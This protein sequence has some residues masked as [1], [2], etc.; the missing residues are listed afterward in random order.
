[1][2]V[3]GKTVKALGLCSGGLDSILSA[4]VLKS[5]GID[6]AWVSFET[7]FFS[8]TKARR[9]SDNTGIPLE[10]RKITDIYL[11][12]LKDPRSGYGKNMNPCKDCHTLMFRLAGEMMK[13]RGFHFLF[14]GEVLEQR[15]LSQTRTSLRY[16]EKHSGMTDYILRPLSAKKLPET[17]P[18]KNG[19]VDRNR[20]L[21]IAG[22][23]RKRQI[24]LARQFGIED[25]PA[26]AGGC[27]LT[28]KNYCRRLKDLFDHG[29]ATREKDLMLLKYGRHFRLGPRLKIIV[30]RTEA[31]NRQI[32][33]FFEPSSDV[34][35]HVRDYPS[36]VVLVTGQW[37]DQGLQLAG[38]ICVGYSK[39]PNSLPVE[40]EVTAASPGAP[41]KV[42]GLSPS[43]ISHLM[44]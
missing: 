21:D 25:Y 40:V 17:V 19:W 12:M 36:P 39:A 16:V 29:G 13:S 1:M 44:I 31:D 11:D 7:P 22:R 23:S 15:P 9:A 2:T 4:L 27:L 34:L 33:N 28:D 14:S 26:P 32:L 18:E 6:V 42:L 3:P 38:A 35:L 43:E 20:L 8:A 24:Q 41:L 37:I 10:V 5:Q 30:G